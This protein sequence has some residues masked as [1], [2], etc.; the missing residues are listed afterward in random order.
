MTLE[1][2]AVPILTP[3]NGVQIIVDFFFFNKYVGFFPFCA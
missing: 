3:D 2:H 1:Y